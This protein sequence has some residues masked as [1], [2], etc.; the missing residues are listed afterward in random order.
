MTCLKRILTKRKSL[1]KKVLWLLTQVK[2]NPI[3]L[4]APRVPAGRGSQISRQSA[5]EGGKVVSTTNR[6]P[7]P[8]GNT[9]GTHFCYKL[10]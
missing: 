8:P 5:N 9:P 3:P 2:I 6:P 7:L 1:L 10:T 4:Q